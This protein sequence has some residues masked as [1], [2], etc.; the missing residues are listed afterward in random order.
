[1]STEQSTPVVPINLSSTV[2]AQERYKKFLQIVSLFLKEPLT[3]VEIS[4]ID[5]F[6]H[7]EAG[8]ITTNSRRQVRENLNMSAAQLNNY[9]RVLRNNKKVIAK[10]S[11]ISPF[12][13]PIPEGE[14]MFIAIKLKVTI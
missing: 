8:N 9:I 11:L 5:E 7:A 4:I 1:M 12:L 10:N 2:Q 14:N 13:Q 6:Y 3:P